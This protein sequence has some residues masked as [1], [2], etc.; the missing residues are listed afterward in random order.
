MR[1]FYNILSRVDLNDVADIADTIC[2][3]FHM[4]QI[5]ENVTNSVLKVSI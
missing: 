2:T 3:G 4:R 5:F 1:M